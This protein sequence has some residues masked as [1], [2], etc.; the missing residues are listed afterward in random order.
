M[1]LIVNWNVVVHLITVHAIIASKGTRV[2]DAHE[3]G[4]R[5]RRSNGS[6]QKLTRRNPAAVELLVGILAFN[7]HA[8]FQA[9]TGEKTLRLRVGE[10]ARDSF[11]A[12]ST[13]SFRVSPDGSCGD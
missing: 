7:Q 8:T 5:W 3:G 9:D 12:G 13:R 11:G 10:N 4:C 1:G 6:T 2:Q